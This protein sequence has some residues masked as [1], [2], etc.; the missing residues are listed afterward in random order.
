M[1]DDS[2]PMTDEVF[3]IRY[4]SIIHRSP[5]TRHLPHPL[6]QKLHKSFFVV[7]ADGDLC[8]AYVDHISGDGIY[9]VQ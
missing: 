5:D 6:T 7:F 8:I 3:I 1:T 9:V 2:C 4:L